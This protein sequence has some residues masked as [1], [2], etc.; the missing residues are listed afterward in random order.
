MF[1]HTQMFSGSWTCYEDLVSWLHG[2]SNLKKIP[3]NFRSEDPFLSSQET[4]ADSFPEPGECHRLK[5]KQ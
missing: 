3:P 1:V 5:L 4:T 2:E